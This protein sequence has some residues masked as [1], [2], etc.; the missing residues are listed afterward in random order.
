MEGARAGQ[1]EGEE[2]AFLQAAAQG[3][4]RGVEGPGRLGKE[5]TVLGPRD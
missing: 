5:K 2:Q 1:G 4:G 3:W